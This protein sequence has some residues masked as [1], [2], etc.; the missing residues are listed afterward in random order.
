MTYLCFMKINLQGKTYTID[1]K[2]I[3]IGIKLSSESKTLKLD[4]LSQEDVQ[5]VVDTWINK[6]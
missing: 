4:G 6:E 2:A 5:V 3:S 1:E